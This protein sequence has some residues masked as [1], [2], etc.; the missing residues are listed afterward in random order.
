MNLSQEA[1]HNTTNPKYDRV[2]ASLQL[3]CPF[4]W[5]CIRHLKLCLLNT[6]CY[7][8][9]CKSL[10]KQKYLRAL[11]HW[12][13]PKTSWHSSPF[14]ASQGHTHYVWHQNEQCDAF[15]FPCPAL[16]T[17]ANTHRLQHPHALNIH[18]G[19]PRLFLLP[20]PVIE[21][22]TYAS[23]TNI[24]YTLWKHPRILLA[25]RSHSSPRYITVP[26]F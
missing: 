15:L 18:T 7:L 11:P 2:Y 16:I 20:S 4:G 19:P 17:H 1:S 8:S 21:W 13:F 9:Q 5:C 12:S 25:N 14:S 6:L 3:L 26:H 22:K 23:L 10:H 24:L